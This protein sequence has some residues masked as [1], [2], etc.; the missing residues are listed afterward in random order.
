MLGTRY[1]LSAIHYSGDRVTVGDF[2]GSVHFFDWNLGERFQTLHNVHKSKVTDLQV[3]PSELLV[4]AS[5]DGT[6][7]VFD[8]NSSSSTSSA[9]GELPIVHHEEGLRYPTPPPSS[10]E[11]CVIS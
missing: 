4:T 5:Q 1:P 6:L 10:K 7:A 9:L 3:T 11:K 8:F 2:S